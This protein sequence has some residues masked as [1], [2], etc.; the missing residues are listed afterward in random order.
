MLEIT[1]LVGTSTHLQCELMSNGD[2]S[3]V[4][5]LLSEKPSGKVEMRMNQEKGEDSVIVSR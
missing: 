3:L 2:V 4:F 5:L 1:G